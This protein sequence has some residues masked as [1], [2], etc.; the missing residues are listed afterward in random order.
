MTRNRDLDTGRVTGPTGVPK[1]ELE[2]RELRP[3][4]IALFTGSYNYIKDGIALTLNR[5]VEYLEAHAVEVL[6]FAPV[7]KSPAFTHKGNL[8][9]VPSLPLPTR[10]EYRVALGLPRAARRRLQALQPD[11]IHIAVPDVLGYR[12]LKLGLKWK[13]PV[14]ASYHTRYETYLKHYGL[15]FLR[16]AL[17]KYLRYFY[18]ACREVYVPSGSMAEVLVAEGVRCNMRLWTRGVDTL[19]FHP[20]K[21][22]YSWRSKYCIGPEE[23][24]VLFVGRLVREK[25]L[26]ILVDIL[27]K[28]RAAGIPHR[29]LIVGDGP[30]RN[31]IKKQL[32]HTLFSGFLDGEELANAYASADIFLFPSNTE[33]FGSVTL[34]AMASGLPCVCADA[35]GSRSLVKPGV[36]G[37][38]AKPGWSHVFVE[39]IRTL[40]ADANLRRRMGIAARERSLHF[41]WEDAMARLLGYYEALLASPERKP[42]DDIS[43]HF[44]DQAEIDARTGFAAPETGKALPQ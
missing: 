4:R 32:P 35:T 7:A 39:H 44:F 21:R 24:V 33:T 1:P 18:G 29:S 2:R 28:F 30:E 41:T 9:P 43:R 27:R 17:V 11:I 8:V 20:D 42:T 14:V 3:L 36:T 12:A 34:E 40:A 38:L 6:V 37:F 15:E 13:L 10:P 23:L 25:Q 5:L 22:S 31:V 16:G 26:G 19:L